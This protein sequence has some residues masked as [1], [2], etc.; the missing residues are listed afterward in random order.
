LRHLGDYYVESITQQLIN[1]INKLTYTVSNEDMLKIF[2]LA[3]N[4]EYKNYINTI[5]SPLKDLSGINDSIEDKPSVNINI[6][7]SCL[8]IVRDLRSFIS[9]LNNKGHKVNEGPQS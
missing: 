7:N 8:F 3:V 2:N 6:L 4:K 9:D 1:S 5:I